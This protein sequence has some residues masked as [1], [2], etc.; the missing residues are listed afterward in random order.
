MQFFSSCYFFFR[1]VSLFSF[2]EKGASVV[3]DVDWIRFS[4]TECQRTKVKRLACMYTDWHSNF[5]LDIWL[6]AVYTTRSHHNAII[7][8]SDGIMVDKQNKKQAELKQKAQTNLRVRRLSVAVNWHWKMLFC[9]WDRNISTFDAFPLSDRNHK[10][11]NN[12]QSFCSLLLTAKNV[13]LTYMVITHCG[14]CER[15]GNKNEKKKKKQ[16]TSEWTIEWKKIKLSNNSSDPRVCVCVSLFISI[17]V[18]FNLI[19]MRTIV[20]HDRLL[21]PITLNSTLARSV[22]HSHRFIGAFITFAMISVRAA[23]LCRLFKKLQLNFWRCSLARYHS[24]EEEKQLHRTNLSSLFSRTF[25]TDA[26]IEL[27]K[28][29]LRRIDTYV[30]RFL[31][32][33]DMDVFFCIKC[34]MKSVDKTTDSPTIERDT[35][36]MGYIAAISIK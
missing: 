17:Y 8:M 12:L 31:Y 6:F 25:L 18:I 27:E 23:W 26:F 21:L 1:S 28:N 13:D 2:R 30:R 16:R 3:R 5:M 33:F 4:V 10:T 7:S 14:D 29:S 22:A 36:D 9:V 34:N 24:Q 15:H 19:P 20:S 11:Y 35:W 32:Q